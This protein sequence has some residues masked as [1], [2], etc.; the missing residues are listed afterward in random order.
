MLHILLLSI[1]DKNVLR[2]PTVVW[3]RLGYLEAIYHL[4]STLSYRHLTEL[5]KRRFTFKIV[6]IKR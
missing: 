4:P 3:L 6:K 2:H 5:I 1:D